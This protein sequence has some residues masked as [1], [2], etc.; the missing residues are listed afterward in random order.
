L[1]Y[2]IMERKASAGQPGDIIIPD[3]VKSR[4]AQSYYHNAAFNAMLSR[5][6]D[7]V[8]A[9]L[10]RAGVTVILIK[11]AALVK[12]LYADPAERPMNDLDLLVRRDQIRP[13][14][15]ALKAAGYQRL[16]DNYIRYHVLMLGGQGERVTVELHW[17]L[18]LND[19]RFP[20]LID[21]FWHQSL[22]IDP[23]NPLTL[24][25]SPT[26]QLLYLAVH[27]A[28]QHG[29]RERLSWFYDLYLLITRQGGQIYWDDLLQQAGQV[30]WAQPLHQTLSAAKA[31]F[32]FALPE[33]FHERLSELAGLESGQAGRLV[34]SSS[35]RRSL[36]VRKAWSGLS[37]GDRLG[38]LRSLVFPRPAYLRWRYQ[39]RPQWLWP[40]CYLR[41]WRAIIKEG[42]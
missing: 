36:S 23:S 24:T 10:T 17:S 29:G 18:V 27:M 5:E 26:A 37:R 15:R 6:L 39:P 3:S 42:I 22:P 38:M 21:W 7:G 31:R 12:I 40:L 14:V 13:A 30:S 1:L 35:D 34:G 4:L 25:L 8:L 19:E 11:G 20:A 2:S 32:G 9:A 16:M 41:R 33:G 28:L